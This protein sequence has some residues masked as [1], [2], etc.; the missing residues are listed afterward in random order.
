M[1]INFII[2]YL[3]VVL[4]LILLVLYD[5]NVDVHAEGQ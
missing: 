1:Y 4:G 2:L 3:N 5:S